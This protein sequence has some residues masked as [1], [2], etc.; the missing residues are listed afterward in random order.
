MEHLQMAQGVVYVLSAICEEWALCNHL[1]LSRAVFH[2]LNFLVSKN[3]F[4]TVF[5]APL[6]N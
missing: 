2:E 3:S 1:C 4:A 5:H 6:E